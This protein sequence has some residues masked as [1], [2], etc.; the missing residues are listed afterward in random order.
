VSTER[1]YRTEGIVIRRRNQGEADRV[2]TLC[3]PLGKIEVIVK[4]R[5]NI[6]AL[7]ADGTIV[8]DF[9]YPLSDEN[10]TGTT[11]PT[12]AVGDLDGDGDVEYVFIS[13]I[14]NLAFF[15]EPHSFATRLAYW[16]MF[17]HDRWNTAYLPPG[18][19]GDVDG[20]GDVDLSDLGALLAAYGTCA[21]QPR[22]NLNADFDGDGCV[23]LSD[24][25][26]LLANYG[27]GT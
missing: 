14:G 18:L 1:L 4:A 6:F 10:H 8:D 7:H 19:I 12:Q 26:A 16:P 9:P 23:G 25:A 24:L 3:T 21:G 2:L 13:S 5:D 22:Y 15:D 20:D 27:V 11:S 17:K